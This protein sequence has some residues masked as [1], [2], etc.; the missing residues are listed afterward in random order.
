MSLFTK[1]NDTSRRG[2]LISGQTIAIIS[3]PW[4][5]PIT[6]RH[7]ADARN[8]ESY[9]YGRQQ[10][11]RLEHAVLYEA[12]RRLPERASNLFSFKSGPLLPTIS[13]DY[14]NRLSARLMSAS[15]VHSW[16]GSVACGTWRRQFNMLILITPQPC[17]RQTDNVARLYNLIN[18][19]KMHIGLACHVGSIEILTHLSSAYQEAQCI[20]TR[21]ALSGND[22]NQWWTNTISTPP[23]PH[24]ARTLTYAPAI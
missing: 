17:H 11:Q 15:R 22:Q 18:Q 19:T 2:Q 24:S 5:I 10:P 8:H 12:C 7:V 1:A 13:I 23:T 16:Y 20:N 14:F 9:P 4:T 21:I 6:C 3:V